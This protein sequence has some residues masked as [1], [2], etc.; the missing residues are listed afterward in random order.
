LPFSG[1]EVMTG[2][3]KSLV[4]VIK[5]LLPKATPGGTNPDIKV[6]L[7]FDEAAILRHEQGGQDQK[8]IPADIICRAI[9]IYSNA[10]RYP[11]W[12]VFAS[13]NSRVADFAAPSKIRTSEYFLL[14][15]NIDELT[16]IC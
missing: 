6:M 13:T 15:E 1:K 5:D 3:Y 12:A 14:V 2:A 4:D 9:S 16:D 8:Y 11:I 10:D 7:G